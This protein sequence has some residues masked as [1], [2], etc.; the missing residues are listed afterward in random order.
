MT[1]ASELTLIEA[2]EAALRQSMVTEV[3]KSLI[4]FITKNPPPDRY[5]EGTDMRVW[6][7][8]LDKHLNPDEQ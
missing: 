6:F 2:T 3:K 8:R 5:R 7:D 4:E 1:T